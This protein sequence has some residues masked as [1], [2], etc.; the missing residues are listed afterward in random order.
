MQDDSKKL[1]S[2]SAG[3]TLSVEQTRVLNVKIDYLIDAAGRLGRI[4]W[5]GVFIG[6][7]LTFVL[8]S[9]F[10]P[11]SVSKFLLMVLRAI[12]HLYGFPGLPSV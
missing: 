11:E 5:R 1:R 9:A 7:M 12:G 6:V 2:A 10:P 4:D 8:A 3:R